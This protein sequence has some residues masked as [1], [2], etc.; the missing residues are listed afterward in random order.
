MVD[1][2]G[3][4]PGL[5]SWQQLAAVFDQQLLPGQ[6]PEEVSRVVTDSRLVQPGDLFVALAGDPGSRFQPS[7]RS[8]VDG[9]SFVQQALAAGAV[10]ALVD[11]TFV[12]AQVPENRLLRVQNTYDGLWQLGRAARQRY[13][14]VVV[15]VTGSSGNTTAKTFLAHALR[16]YAPP[17]S[18]NNHIGVPL[19]L[20]NLP[21]QGRAAVVEIGTNHPGEI[22]PLAQMVKPD[23]AVLLN[24]HQAH[25]ENFENWQALKEE[26]LSIFNA[27]DDISHCIYEDTL[28]LGGGHSFGQSSGSRVQ[29]RKLQG[30]SAEYVLDGE[31]LTATVPGGG[32]HRALTVAA[33]L[34]TCHLIGDGI[35]RATNLPQSL[36]PNGRGRL[37]QV[38]DRVVVDDSYNANPQSMAAGLEAALALAHRGN[39]IAVVGEMLE[40]GDLGPAAHAGLVPLL[41]Q[42]E[43]V[44]CVGEAWR[45][46][47]SE[48]GAAWF[49]TAG[50]GLLQ[51]LQDSPRHSLIVVKGS[52]R[53]FWA[54]DFVPALLNR[55]QELQAS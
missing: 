33:T 41:Q 38:A 21:A 25:I 45:Q 5:W 53:V 51:A 55:F 12:N 43:Q 44:Y 4:V 26:K 6:R 15:A 36:V 24:V 10:G 20:A 8:T 48:I 7:H 54:A 1:Y 31:T 40:L 9:H 14:G 17:G 50:E 13:Q 49:E 16:A 19:T 46:V 47:A 32:M 2:F 29:L 42:F 52:N 18:F 27:L 28:E 35:T 3:P 23:W 11:N 37:H 34:L 39:A 30:T 22:E